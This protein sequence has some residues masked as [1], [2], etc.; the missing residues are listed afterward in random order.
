LER[1]VEDEVVEAGHG[2]EDGGHRRGLVDVEPLREVLPERHRDRPPGLRSPGGEGDHGGQDARDRD[3][4]ARRPQEDA[5][6]DHRRS[7][8]AASLED[9]GPRTST[10][11]V[12]RRAAPGR[13]AP[14]PTT[15]RATISPRSSWTSIITEYSHGASVPGWRMVPSTTRGHT[16]AR[17]GRATATASN[18]R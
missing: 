12:N 4:N 13:S 7:Q 16:A 2:R 8:D 3:G 6:A 5:A 11:R 18:R 1:V 17:A 14:T 15:R 10:R 9:S